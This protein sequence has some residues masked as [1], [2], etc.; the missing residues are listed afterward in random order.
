MI[1]V[2]IEV[3]VNEVLQCIGLMCMFVL[4]CDVWQGDGINVVQDVVGY[5]ISVDFGYVQM[6]VLW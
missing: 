1:I 2:V 4:Q 5:W 3:I 6:F